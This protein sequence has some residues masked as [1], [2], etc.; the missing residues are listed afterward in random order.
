MYLGIKL[1]LPLASITPL[2]MIV[3]FIFDRK[4]ANNLDIDNEQLRFTLNYKPYFYHG[5]PPIIP[6]SHCSSRGILVLIEVSPTFLIS[7]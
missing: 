7:V 6:V 4:S 5:N 3:L 2:S 1:P